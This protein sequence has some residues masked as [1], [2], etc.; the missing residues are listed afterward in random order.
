[1][2]LPLLQH[3]GPAVPALAPTVQPSDGPALCSRLHSR[4]QWPPYVPLD[5]PRLWGAVRCLAVVLQPH[6]LQVDHRHGQF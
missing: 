6:T 5:L 3:R 1:M 2:K 4:L